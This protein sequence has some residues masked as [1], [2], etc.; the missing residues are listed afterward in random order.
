MG[1]SRRWAIALT[2]GILSGCAPTPEGGGGGGPSTATPTRLVLQLAGVFDDDTNAPISAEVL[3]QKGWTIDVA[4]GVATFQNP[5][6]GTEHVKWQVP[7]PA[8]PLSAVGDTPLSLW[9][10]GDATSLSSNRLTLESTMRCDGCEPHKVFTAGAD[11]QDGH[12]AEAPRI[13]AE[14]LVPR[15]RRLGDRV[16]IAVWPGWF[17]G[18]W[19]IQYVYVLE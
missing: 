12:P 13:Q 14:F 7:A 11:S 5:R 18:K 3:A 10:S 15:N 17:F 9:I 2:L 4:G 19:S 16:A 1:V 8:I 6:Y